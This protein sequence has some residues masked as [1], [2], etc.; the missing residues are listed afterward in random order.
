MN[1]YSNTSAIELNLIQVCNITE[2]FEKREVMKD[3]N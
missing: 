2:A 3:E 1:L